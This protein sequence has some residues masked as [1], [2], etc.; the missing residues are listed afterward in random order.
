MI[1]LVRH[2]YLPWGSPVLNV[3]AMLLEL[4]ELRNHPRKGHIVDGR[5]NI[6][7]IILYIIDSFWVTQIIT[8]QN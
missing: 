3:E 4:E 8:D 7:I 2:V 5:H 6:I 1:Y